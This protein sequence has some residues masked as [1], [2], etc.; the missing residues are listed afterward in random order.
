MTTLKH[1]DHKEIAK[2][3]ALILQDIRFGSIEVVIHDGRVVHIDKRE[4]FRVTEQNN[5]LIPI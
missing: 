1:Q 3:I 5:N 2:H 4:R